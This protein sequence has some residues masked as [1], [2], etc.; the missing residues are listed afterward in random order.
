MRSSSWQ[1]VAGATAFSAA[2]YLASLFVVITRGA[3]Y[4]TRE[5]GIH[6]GQ[7]RFHWLHGAPATSPPDWNFRIHSY[8]SIERFWPK[9][10][11]PGGTFPAFGDIIIPL[12]PIP[13]ITA[14]LSLAT[15]ILSI[16]SPRN[17]RCTN[18]GYDLSGT[19]PAPC[20]ECGTMPGTR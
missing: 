13:L 11:V 20:P 4:G 10:V 1:A 16:K 19:G 8:P 2:V 15:I 7:L 14:S 6:A 9:I 3:P 5:L 18:C 12:W 17:Q